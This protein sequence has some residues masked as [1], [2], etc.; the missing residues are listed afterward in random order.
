MRIGLGLSSN[1][2][3]TGELARVIADAQELERQGFD[4]AWSS[5]WWLPPTGPVVAGLDPLA[6][7]TAVGAATTR[8]EL[9]TSVVPTYHRPPAVMAQSAL[10]VRSAAPG[11]FVLGLGVAHRR[12]V[13]DV[14]GL[15]YAPPAPHMR[16]Y[17]EALLPI[18]AGEPVDHDAGPLS[19]RGYQIPG[20]EPM[21]VLVAAM[22]P[23]MLRVAGELADGTITAL[24]GPRTLESHIVPSITRAAE[25]AG[26]PSPR[27]VA[28]V[29][30]AVT[31][32]VARARGLAAQAMASY[33]D[34]PAY[35][36][37][38][39]R[40]E[41]EPGDLVVAGDAAEVQRT[42]RRLEDIGVTDVLAAVLPVDEQ[43]AP[44]TVQALA[45]CLS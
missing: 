22:G 15:T 23:L 13:E 25:A 16:R 41:A 12:L 45:G 4:T 8:I 11:R 5:T 36:A 24:T 42:I 38:L 27:I 3:A 7:L 18:F 6:A 10:T 32:D 43:T 20:A 14:M 9:G 34:L 29:T 21:P 19:V 31:D 39:D 26:R 40:E 44:R 35:R 37:M 1:S 28:A 30:F 17:L 2:G 33:K